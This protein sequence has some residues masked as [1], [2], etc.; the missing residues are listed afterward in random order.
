MS[1]FQ[2]IASEI[3]LPT[4]VV[5]LCVG[6]VYGAKFLEKDADPGALRYASRVLTAGDL[7][8]IGKAGA[9]LVPLVF[10]KIFGP[11]PVSV[12]FASASII[13]TSLFWLV[14]LIIKHIPLVNLKTTYA[15]V[16]YFYLT[17][18]P[19][20]YIL[21]WISLAK[22]RF[23]IRAISP[24]YSI[25]SS[26]FFLSTDVLL[27][28]L[29]LFT[30]TTVHLFSETLFVTVQFEEVINS[31]LYNVIPDFVDLSVITDYFTTESEHS[32]FFAVLPPSTLL[33]SVWTFLLFISAILAQLLVPIEYLRRVT[34]YWFKDV[35]KQPLTAIAKVAATLIVVGAMAIK[36]VRWIY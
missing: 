21:D 34:R 1:I 22:A 28:Y 31:F 26:L 32:Y 35:E 13:A 29:L 18:M 2:D 8:S 19:F 36:A 7:R 30:F 9:T 3:G 4:G 6:L 12:R 24:K 10:D 23:L 17:V 33:T 11:K 27:S 20:W 15:T 14:L 25:S 5:G 16:P